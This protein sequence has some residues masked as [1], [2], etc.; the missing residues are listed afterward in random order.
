MSASPTPRPGK[1]GRKKWALAVVIAVVA[2][3]VVGYVAYGYL[4]PPKPCCAPGPAPGTLFLQSY[5][6]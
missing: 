3:L 6:F 4:Y 1:T 2:A 5:N